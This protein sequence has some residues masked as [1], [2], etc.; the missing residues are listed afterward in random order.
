MVKFIE[1]FH[2][3]LCCTV[4]VFILL[5][6]LCFRHLN[7]TD[8]V[9]PTV[10]RQTENWFFSYVLYIGGGIHLLMSIAMATTYF[11]INGSNFVLPAFFYRVTG[12]FY[13]VTV[14][15]YHDT[16]FFYKL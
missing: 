12:Y 6:L 10:P 11:L 3:K 9:V 15:F 5:K 1:I 14:Y 4:M 7:G 13:R 2:Q 8:I 16:G